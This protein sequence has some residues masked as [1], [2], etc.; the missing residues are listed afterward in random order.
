MN[1]A[2]I[3][4]L[5]EAQLEAVSS[6][7]FHVKENTRHVPHAATPY[8]RSTLLP[9]ESVRHTGITDGLLGLFQV[10][11]CYPQGTGTAAASAMAQAIKTAFAR[12]TELSATGTRLMVKMSWIEGA[13]ADEQQPFYCV[14]VLVRWECL[15][16]KA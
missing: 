10:D 9:A 3:R 12:G 5:L 13:D 7:P 11:A 14:P 1:L 4:T 2:T 16:P 8:V 6:L 15:L